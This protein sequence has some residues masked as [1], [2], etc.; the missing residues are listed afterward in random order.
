MSNI[1]AYIIVE[2]KTERTFIWEI[3]APYLACKGIYLHPC[4]IGDPGHKGGDVRFEGRAKSEVGKFLKQR[5]DTYVSTMLDFYKIDSC[6]PGLNELKIRLNQGEQLS[7]PE[8][9][10]VIEKATFIAI[11]SLYPQLNVHNRF[12]P[13]IQMHEFEALLFSDTSKLAKA[14]KQDV[15]VIDD[16]LSAYDHNPEKINNHPET[17]PA[18]RLRSLVSSYKKVIMGNTIA[19]AIGIATMRQQCH[20]FNQWLDKLENLPPLTH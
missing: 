8:K 10:K 5:K 2:G 3:L 20:H 9:A 15:A 16:I 19:K 18:K 6:W 17:A 1:T 4:L 14:I 7:V 11:H 12:I 13:Y